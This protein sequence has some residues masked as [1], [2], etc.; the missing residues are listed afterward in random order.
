MFPW[1][2]PPEPLRFDRFMAAALHDPSQGYY[3]RRIR[4]VGARGDFSTTATLSPALGTAIA[5]WAV[6]AMAA[7][8]CRDLIELGPG[9]GELASTVLRNLPWH[10]RLRIRLHLVE[11]S[12]PLRK[13]QQERLGSRVRFHETAAE[14]LAACDGKACLY[15]NEFADA[16]PVRRFRREKEG[17]HECHLLPGE[18]LW[19]ATERLPDSTLFE[20]SFPVGQII[21]VAE[22]YH[23]WLDESLARWKA[24]RMLTIDYGSQVAD[25]YRRQPGGSVRAYFH[26][27]H[28]TGA[29][30]FARPGHQDLTADV[31]FSDLARWSSPYAR[32]LRLITQREFLLP[33]IRPNEAADRHSVDEHGA[34]HAFLVSE[35]EALT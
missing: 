7:T 19:R 28:L 9:S 2:A 13:L 35:L 5:D 32:Q 4:D 26:H 23:D 30:A 3:A 22:A 6:G 16:F 31:N 29:E 25:L 21:E 18:E 10:R 24:G 33:H 14:A 27:Q 17:W 8:D 15:S 12:A 34:G 11:S 20:R 1:S